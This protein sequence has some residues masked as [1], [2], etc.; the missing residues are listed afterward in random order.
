MNPTIRIENSDKSLSASDQQ[1][2]AVRTR[3]Q[4]HHHI[5]EPVRR[6]HPLAQCCVPNG[7][8]PVSR[9]RKDQLLIGDESHVV[10]LVRL[11]T[12]G[13]D[14]PA[15]AQ[16]PQVDPSVF[17]G[18]EQALAVLAE[19][20]GEHPSRMLEIRPG[21]GHRCRL[22]ELNS[23]R[24]T[25]CETLA[26]RRESHV[27]NEMALR[28]LVREHNLSG[29]CLANLHFAAAP[30]RKAIPVRREPDPVANHIA[31]TG[32]ETLKCLTASSQFAGR[33]IEQ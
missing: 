15:G 24:G 20:G 13:Q 6:R 29:G 14:F 25:G 7:D 18:R 5:R 33:P 19:L 12:C 2:R 16:V 8:L 9:R 28:L 1:I 31:V 32:R 26:I 3:R 11:Q 21:A 22:P 17:A 4:L 23:V 10:D 27:V 30:D